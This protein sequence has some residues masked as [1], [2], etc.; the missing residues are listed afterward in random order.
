M[1]AKKKAAK[2]K[3]VKKPVETIESKTLGA[4]ITKLETQR[5]KTR[6]AKAAAKAEEEA[7]RALEAAINERMKDADLIQTTGKEVRC[8]RRDVVMPNVVD[9]D[10]LYDYIASSGR[11]DLLHR[12]VGATACQDLWAE[13]EVVPGV[14]PNEFVKLF[15]TSR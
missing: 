6:K 15:I 7:E 1:A 14:E 5:K 13:G 3:P 9:W 10:V 12:R 4:L 11:F 2:K 8:E